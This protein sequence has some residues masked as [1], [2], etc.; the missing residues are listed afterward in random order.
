MIDPIIIIIAIGA[1]GGV[2]RC[3]LGYSEQSDP[4]EAFDY[5]KLAKS[6]A[7]AAIAGAAVVY[8]ISSATGSEI[9]T[10]TYISAFFVAI[11][12]EVITKEGYSVSKKVVA[13]AVGR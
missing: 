7:R 9:T 10:A 12:V 4:G 13:K 11:G 5:V 6:V 2:V 3:L 8:G 1:L